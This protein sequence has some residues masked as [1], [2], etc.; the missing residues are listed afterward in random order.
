MAISDEDLARR[1]SISVEQVELLRLTRG[2]TNDTLAGLSETAI[3]RAIRRLSVPDLPRERQAFR[4][5]QARNDDG[6][7]PPNALGQA[8]EQ[9]RVERAPK[10]GRTSVAGLPPDPTV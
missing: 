9:L 5:Q 8:L 2:A 1:K 4:A 7:I 10:A 6:R 3:R